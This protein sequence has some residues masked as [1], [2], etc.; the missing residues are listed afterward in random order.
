M[1][2][3][4]ER[5]LAVKECTFGNLYADDSWQCFTLEDKDRYLEK[6]YP[7]VPRETAIPRGTYRLVLDWSNRFNRIMPHIL[8][9]PQFKGVRIHS[10]NTTDDTEGCILVGYKVGITSIA[11]SQKA[12]YQLFNKLQSC[13]EPMTI[14]VK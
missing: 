10:G 7:K 13:K 11:E 2:L 4:L 12:F 8:D 9:V 5:S 3:L 14:E 1:N 6:G